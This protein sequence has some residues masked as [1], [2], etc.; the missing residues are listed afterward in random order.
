[1]S[2]K[3]VYKYANVGVAVIE[4]ILYLMVPLIPH[5]CDDQFEGC[6]FLIGHRQRMKDVLL[7]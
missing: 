3:S 5:L 4:K 2:V 6:K 1:M 7:E